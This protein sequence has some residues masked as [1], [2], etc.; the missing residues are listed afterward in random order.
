MSAA[1]ALSCEALGKR[2]G[3]ASSFQRLLT[4]LASI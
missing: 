4:A 3:V 1:L 2:Y